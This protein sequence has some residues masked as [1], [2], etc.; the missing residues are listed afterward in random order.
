MSTSASITSPYAPLRPR[1]DSGHAAD[2]PPLMATSS[3]TTKRLPVRLSLSDPRIQDYL[4]PAP[5]GSAHNKAHSPHILPSPAL[6]VASI[7][8]DWKPKEKLQGRV[9]QEPTP[10]HPLEV[11]TELG[12]EHYLP[13]D[14]FPESVHLPP[15]QGI[16]CELAI[17]VSEQ[18]LAAAT[19]RLEPIHMRTFT[20]APSAVS[21]GFRSTSSAPPPPTVSTKNH[22]P[23]TPLR[24]PSRDGQAILLTSTATAASTAETPLTGFVNMDYYS[25]YHQDPKSLHLEWDRA[26]QTR[27]LPQRLSAG[28][29][30][31][32]GSVVSHIPMAKSQGIKKSRGKSTARMSATTASRIRSHL[33]GISA[34]DFSR[35]VSS[36]SIHE[37]PQS[38]RGIA[39]TQVGYWSDRNS[40]KDAMAWSWSLLNDEPRQSVKRRRSSQMTIGAGDT[41]ESGPIPTSKRVKKPVKAARVKK[42]AKVK[43]DHEVKLENAD[44]ASSTS[45]EGGH[46]GQRVAF[47]VETVP[48]LASDVGPIASLENTPL[49]LVQW[50]GTP[51]D[52]SQ[53]PGFAKLHSHEVYVASTL[54]L[55]P[56]VYLSCKQ[57]LVS[58]SRGYAKTGKLFRKSD[59]Q[60][61]CKIDVN[62]TSKLWEVFAKFG[63]LSNIPGNI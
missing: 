59:A 8:S 11:H 35:P 14:M 30:H 47:E 9:W 18:R 16:D 24:S 36:Q 1:T 17:S 43:A 5:Y 61:L 52:I 37:T 46:G 58:A 12:S 45:S 62:K 3:S 7:H 29:T 6:S 31:T 15:L 38:T 33:S 57:T 44:R 49:P 19:G 13:A 10:L 20:Q 55:T 32:S 60:K 34:E 2:W 42:P 23:D 4:G 40:D 26:R 22:F 28:M 56:A 53:A 25:M 41:H 48:E 51:L 50:K 21:F 27:Q 54:R 63:W 39:M